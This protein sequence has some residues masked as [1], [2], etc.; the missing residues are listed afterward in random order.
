MLIITRLPG[1]KLLFGLLQGVSI[2][3]DL[4][5]S[6]GA[7]DIAKRQAA[8][9]SAIAER[10]RNFKPIRSRTPAGDTSVTKEGFEFRPSGAGRDII[11]SLGEAGTKFGERL[12]Q[13]S[14]K[15]ASQQ[16]L[17]LLRQRRAPFFASELQ[18]L[19]SQLIGKGTLNL[20]TGARAI[21]PE[22]EAFFGAEAQNDLNLMLASFGEGRA[23]RQALLRDTTAAGEGFFQFGSGQSQLPG[24]SLAAE[25]R[26]Q[27]DLASARIGGQGVNVLAQGQ[28]ADLSSQ[29]AFFGSLFSTGL[30]LGTAALTSGGSLFGGGSGAGGGFGSVNQGLDFFS[31]I[32]NV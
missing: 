25:N 4:F 15:E 1:L 31:T 6:G 28:L 23:Q 21:Q 8:S 29:D 7:E 17:D 26:L 22:L 2:F 27:R 20:E 30:R 14:E 13:F 19:R 32:R 9:L 11:G 3:G 16:A 10:I 24:L 18:R 5:G 12:E